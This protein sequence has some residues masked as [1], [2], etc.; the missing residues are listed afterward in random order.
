MRMRPFLQLAAAMLVA[1]TLVQP[2]FAQGK[3]PDRPIRLV[4]PFAPGGETDLIGRMWAQKVAPYLGGTI[5]IDN[6]AGAGGS[7]GSAEVARA[8]PDGY[9]LLSGQTTTHV[10]NPIAMTNPTYDP[11]KD[12]SPITVVSTTPTSILVHPSVPAKNLQELIALIKASPGKFSFGSAGSGT[13]TNL[14]GELFKLQAG[15]LDLQHVPYKGA[16]PGI[17]DLIA[18]HI[19]MFTPILSSTVLAHHRAGRLRILAVNSDVRLKAAPDLPTSIESG[20]P[21]MRVQV[22]NAM[23]AP[24][25]TPPAVIEALHQATVKAKADESFRMDLERAGA[26]LVADSSPEKAAAFI[27]DEITRWT[28]IIK[29]SGFKID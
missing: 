8:R 4:V 5:V 12:F 28:P 1:P 2:V 15:G 10:I 26:E 24:A 18:G 11:L 19:P 17:Q 9:T 25:G 22:F 20:M 3:Y 13:I 6:K 14:T 27:R 21:G 16:G 7:I 23:F 29:A